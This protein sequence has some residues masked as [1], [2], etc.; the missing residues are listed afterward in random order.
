MLIRNC[1]YNGNTLGRQFGGITDAIKYL[2]PEVMRGWYCQQNT[3]NTA[4]LKI[5]GYP[6]AT[7]PPYSLIMGDSAG[8]MSATTTIY[9][10]NTFDNLNLAG[11]LNGES[12]LD[13]SSTLTGMADALAYL[14]SAISG[15]SSIIADIQGAVNIASNLAGS[16]DLTGSLGAL[17][18]ILADLSGSGDLTGDI[19]G[20]LDAIA[21]LSGNGD[22][23]GAIQ[24]S[25][26]IISNISGTS[27]LTAAIIGNWDMICTVAGTSSL[28]ADVEALANLVSALS[29]NGSISLTSGSL[30]GDMFCDI[31]MCGD[32][33]PTN[34][35]T[36]VWE[37]LA[38]S[39]N[40]PGT[41][42]EIMNN[43]GAATDPW[44]VALEGTYTAGDLLKLISAAIAG[45]S[46]RVSTSG[47]ATITFR[48]V[49][50]TENRIVATL[51]N[52]ERTTVI[53]NP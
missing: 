13:G 21:T 3:D 34:V 25:V 20:A 48:D 1:T 8:L 6:T 27:A 9:Q 12:V 32:L 50:D 4:M 45:K 49:N 24:G 10:F 47:V 42:G 17:I 36:A 30:P 26:S 2:K 19:A 52:S 41:M 40:N 37:S 16:G 29:G 31:V 43:M 46:D 5:S 33:T 53:L 18:S 22:L 23:V 28:T 39:F 7:R 44:T 15:T 38:A 14:I 51:Q 11:G 35:A